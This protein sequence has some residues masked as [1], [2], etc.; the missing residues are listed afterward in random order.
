[1]TE[2]IRFDKYAIPLLYE[3]NHL[4]VAVKPANLPV[5]GDSSGDMDLL[6]ILK[7]WDWCTAWTARWGA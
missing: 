4:L 5:Q 7:G 1:M 2:T 6:S 3:D